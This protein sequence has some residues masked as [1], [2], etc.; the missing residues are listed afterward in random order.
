MEN[1]FLEILRI[2][3]YRYHDKNTD[4]YL[5]PLNYYKLLLSKQNITQTDL[6]KI[7]ENIFIGN[8]YLFLASKVS[9]NQ[10]LMDK[11]KIDPYKKFFTDS[12]NII[13]Y[14]CYFLKFLVN[15]NNDKVI[16]IEEELLFFNIKES[17]SESFNYLLN[18]AK[19]KD[20]IINI[21]NDINLFS[22][23]NQDLI[24]SIFDNDEFEINRSSFK[25]QINYDITSNFCYGLLLYI[26]DNDLNSG[27][28]R[29]TDYNFDVSIFYII[30][31]LLS[32]N[33]NEINLGKI[34]NNLN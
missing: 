13:F 8:E 11:T 24:R 27:I 30:F 26:K 31:S 5:F 28:K 9:S 12:R 29:S 34:Y 16:E 22:K 1:L 3:D 4:F 7:A 33:I 20:P 14:I 19:N 2:I 32:N 6:T 21:Y 15:L 25:T 23:E 10:E 18:H 17:L